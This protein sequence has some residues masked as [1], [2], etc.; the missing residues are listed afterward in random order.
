MVCMLC[1]CVWNCCDCCCCYVC[2]YVAIESAINDVVADVPRSKIVAAFLVATLFTAFVFLVLIF[3]N[4]KTSCIFYI[5]LGALLL[6]SSGCFCV[7]LCLLCALHTLVPRSLAFSS[8][9]VKLHV[10]AEGKTQLK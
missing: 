2:F 7:I 8:Y 4:C 6:S 1:V 3:C 5:F 10:R 9:F